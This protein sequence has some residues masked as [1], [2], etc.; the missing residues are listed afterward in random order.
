[1]SSSI[2]SYVRMILSEGEPPTVIQTGMTTGEWWDSQG[3]SYKGSLRD[4]PYFVSGDQKPGSLTY[5]GDPFTYEE[6]E[7]GKLRVVS[8]PNR[9]SI[10]AVIPKPSRPKVTKSEEEKK[11]R[12]EEKEEGK[13]QAS[14]P[15]KTSIDDII[16]LISKN[17][18]LMS[19]YLVK[20]ITFM[21]DLKNTCL[22]R[23]PEQLMPTAESVGR[24]VESNNVG[25]K[26]IIQEL[27]K[28]AKSQIP[29]IAQMN[30]TEPEGTIQG[31]ES[32][33]SGS[34]ENLSFSYNKAFSCLNTI[35]K[36]IKAL[37]KKGDFSWDKVG[38]EAKTYF[39]D[40]LTDTL[41][42]QGNFL[43]SDAAEVF[44]ITN[45][46]ASGTSYIRMVFGAGVG[47]EVLRINGQD[48]KLPELRKDLNE[49]IRLIT[50]E[51]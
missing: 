7:D 31:I 18:R 30:V 14:E 33:K 6:I 39:T 15:A 21:D 49:S 11:T 8:G 22:E 16:I 23:S 50:S 2:R 12:S 17:A 3:K 47:K 44:M 9:K 38:E 48:Y 10:G 5:P 28:I 45:V 27:S 1:M 13:P 34:P 41:P 35:K 40:T 43:N 42:D 19:F 24:Y 51:P 26:K 29:N 20:S 32:L 36:G 4:T 25:Y 37:N 46:A